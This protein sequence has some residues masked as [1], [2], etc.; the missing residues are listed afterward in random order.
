MPEMSGQ[1]LG[2]FSYVNA[3]Q[4][5]TV[6]QPSPQNCSIAARLLCGHQEWLLRATGRH[7]SAICGFWSAFSYHCASEPR[8]GS[9]LLRYL[10]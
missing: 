2:V 9:S 7:W 6:K 1:Q 10:G 3:E 4:R 5:G 8:A